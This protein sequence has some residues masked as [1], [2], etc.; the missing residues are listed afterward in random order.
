MFFRSNIHFY[1]ND[2]VMDMTGMEIYRLKI[3]KETFFSQHG[4]NNFDGHLIACP[5][6][7][8]QLSG[9]YHSM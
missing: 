4:M 5:N 7:E 1:E 6:I 2:L 9:N 3:I 8:T